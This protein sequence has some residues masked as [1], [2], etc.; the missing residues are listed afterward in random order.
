MTQPAFTLYVRKIS[1]DK[2]LPI[3]CPDRASVDAMIA[4]CLGG[5]GEYDVA[6]VVVHVP[7]T[8]VAV[9]RGERHVRV[10]VA[11]PPL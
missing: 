5:S 1:A 8:N 4:H 7:R 9:D 6:R 2:W 11:D 10:A 3:G